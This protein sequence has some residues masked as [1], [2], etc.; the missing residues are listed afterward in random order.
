METL[1]ENFRGYVNEDE[2]QTKESLLKEL[3][4]LLGNWPACQPKNR[5]KHSMAC[6]YHKELEEVVKKYGG[7]GCPAGSHDES[8]EY[9]EEGWSGAITAE[10]AAKRNTID[11][12]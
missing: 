1:I 3:E 9:V 10:P 8:E 5:K 11:E 6:D 7:A 4:G 12:M 2:S